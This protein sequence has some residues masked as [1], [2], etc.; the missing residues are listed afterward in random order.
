MTRRV[1]ESC[2]ADVARSPGRA[3]APGASSAAAAAH[4]PEGATA[5]IVLSLGQSNGRRRAPR[6]TTAAVANVRTFNGGS[7]TKDQATW[8]S[9]SSMPAWSEWGSLVPF[10]EDPAGEGWGPGFC[11]TFAGGASLAH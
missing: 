6:V 3:C 1:A 8:V 7:E 5:A 10:T 9:D 4:I 11:E 2:A